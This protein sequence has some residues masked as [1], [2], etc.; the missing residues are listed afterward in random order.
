[1]ETKKIYQPPAV[2]VKN[3]VIEGVIANSVKIKVK[4]IEWE[5]EKEFKSIEGPIYF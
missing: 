1:M 5:E 4:E 2:E 3:V